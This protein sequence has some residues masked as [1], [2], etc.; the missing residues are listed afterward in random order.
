MITYEVS[1]E[2]K[3]LGRIVATNV[4]GEKCTFSARQE[5]ESPDG[6]FRRHCLGMR[7]QIEM[8]GEWQGRPDKRLE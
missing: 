1:Q 6:G 8:A 2:Q 4:T 5:N 3:E 7:E